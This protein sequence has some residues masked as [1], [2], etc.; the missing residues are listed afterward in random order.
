MWCS[1]VLYLFATITHTVA[2]THK[3]GCAFIAAHRGHTGLM[4]DQNLILPAARLHADLIRH[5]CCGE[6]VRSV[7]LNVTRLEI[8]TALRDQ[9]KHHAHWCL[10]GRWRQSHAPL[11]ELC[12][13]P[14]LSES[15]T[16]IYVYETEFIIGL[17]ALL[18][19]S[20]VIV[21]C[22]FTMR[23]SNVCVIAVGRACG[24]ECTYFYG[25]ICLTK[26]EM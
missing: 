8:L 24:F 25:L 23:R 17:S 9:Q 13:L 7:L 20:L 11:S 5:Q 15:N 6:G 21:P 1:P 12:C 18:S 4:S 26:I 14:K 22:F 16:I 2:H 19:V 10:I 3:P